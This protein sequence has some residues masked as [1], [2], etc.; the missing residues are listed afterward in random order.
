M[1]LIKKED[2]S[3]EIVPYDL[4]S[5][6]PNCSVALT[7]RLP[8]K[9]W[10]QRSKVV[11]EKTQSKPLELESGIKKHSF[12]Q[13]VILPK[14]AAEVEPSMHQPQRFCGAA[15]LGTPF[16]QRYGYY[17]K[18]GAGGKG[19]R[20]SAFHNFPNASMPQP[21]TVYGNFEP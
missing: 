21:K 17:K 20:T 4:D 1:S 8:A 13:P 5:Q 10:G 19:A 6:G 11:W 16:Y 15:A 18:Y 9:S 12:S 7:S 14:A 3:V 2:G